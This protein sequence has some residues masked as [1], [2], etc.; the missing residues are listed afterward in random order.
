MLMLQRKWRVCSQTNSFATAH[1]V[2]KHATSK[3]PFLGTSPYVWHHPPTQLGWTCCTHIYNDANFALEHLTK[4]GC[5][6]KSENK[7]PCSVIC[8]CA[9]C[10][11]CIQ[12]VQCTCNETTCTVA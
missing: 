1:A 5:L 11:K 9:L 4:C 6:V 7:P 12:N 3:S 2:R 8:H 10:S